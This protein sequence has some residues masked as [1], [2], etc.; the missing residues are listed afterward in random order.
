MRRKTSRSATRSIPALSR[1]L[2]V[3]YVLALAGESGTGFSAI[4]R[5]LDGLPAPTL[6]RLLKSL[7]VEGYVARTDAG[8]Y[9]CGQ[10]LIDLCAARNTG[11]ATLEEAARAALRDYADRTGESAA[12][13]SFFGD[14]LVL[15]EKV[16]VTDGFKLASRG[17]TFPPQPQE[18]PAVVV[19]AHLPEEAL[20]LF[21]CSGGTAPA[22]QSR[23]RGAAAS[24]RGSAP[25]IEPMPG[26]PV[27]DG[28][29]RI[30]VP[31][32]GP[33]GLPAGEIHTV[34]PWSR[35]AADR[36]KLCLC[37]QDAATRISHWLAAGKGNQE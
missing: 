11:A 34:V 15:T 19:A 8:L 12:F 21:V 28:P 36:E 25:H 7:I 9:C 10:K 27:K 18:G 17:C 29:R 33:D 35:F 31:V 30:C 37:L 24:A 20:S 13:A 16:E 4:S 23:F 32:L 2:R 3:L 5:H 14:R 6:S 1:G 26:R 22:D